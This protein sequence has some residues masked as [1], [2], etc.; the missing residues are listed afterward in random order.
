VR[1]PAAPRMP[2][3]PDA[4]FIPEGTDP[5]E[6]PLGLFPSEIQ[7]P[8]ALSDFREIAPES[9]KA[10]PTRPARAAGIA[11]RGFLILTIALLV[12]VFA[13][14]VAVLHRVAPIWRGMVA[15]SRRVLL[16]ALGLCVLAWST[17]RRLRL[18]RLRLPAWHLPAWR[19][20]TLR[21][22]T[23]PVPTVGLPAFRQR[24]WR[25]P[26]WR[27][28]S[29]RVVAPRLSAWRPPTWRVPA[30]WH[31]PAWRL[32]ARRVAAWGTRV[33]PMGSAARP[34]VRQVARSPMSAIALAAFACGFIS[35]ASALWL[36]GVSR[37]AGVKPTASQQTPF[38]AS[39]ATASSVNTVGTAL[40][41]APAVES[42]E[43]A[44]TETPASA[45]ARRTVF[46]GS[47]VVNS[48]PSG[49]RVFLNGRSVGQTPLVLRNQPAGSR[50][51]RVALDGYEPWSSAVQVVADS[52]TR[53]RAELK[54]QQAAQP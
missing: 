44:I 22:P 36:S 24:P 4:V 21:V 28:P 1:S 9:H 35:G 26:N 53:L 51:V 15:M 39:L 48:R 37:H 19:P 31:V 34:I 11:A 2:L 17:V 38:D 27:L 25:L 5:P 54:I 50:A 13:A 42:T 41:S 33:A 7:K 49:A 6:D 14:V 3:P 45:G 46:R 29:W 47:L 18:P 52:E 40:A 30:S 12:R 23:L 10:N 43:A 32:P 8:P 20:P 16:L